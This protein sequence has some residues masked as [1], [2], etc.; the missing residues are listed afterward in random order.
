MLLADCVETTVLSYVSKTG[1][2]IKTKNNKSEAL[3]T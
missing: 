2:F 1:K 3:P